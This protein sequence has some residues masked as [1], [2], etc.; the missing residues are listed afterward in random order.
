[1]DLTKL[2][3]GKSK[4]KSL[5][6]SATSEYTITI[7]SSSPWEPTEVK[8]KEYTNNS[9]RCRVQTVL[10]LTL[11]DS[12]IFRS[13]EYLD[14]ESTYKFN[15]FVDPAECQRSTETSSGPHDETAGRLC[16]TGISPPLRLISYFGINMRTSYTWAVYCRV[17]DPA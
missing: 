10:V 8:F 5:R 1:M 9:L 15:S 6:I 11:L 2:V 14:D 3:E 4:E 17:D 13:A 16:P 12:T 7:T